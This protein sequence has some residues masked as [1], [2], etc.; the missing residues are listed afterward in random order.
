MRIGFLITYFYPKIGGAENNC[1]AL[2]REL[3][4]K[5]EVHVFCS[6]E[7][8]Q[9]EKIFGINVHRC[10]E[11][12]RI[13][14]YF[15]F[16]PSLIKKL[17][18][19]ELDILHVHGLGFP[20]HDNAIIKLKRLRPGLKLVC[21]PHGPFMAL[22]KYNLLGK[23]FKFFYTPIIARSMKKF[24]K[25]IQVNPNQWKW[26][27]SEYNIPK[28]K[29]VFLPNGIDKA[30]LKIPDHQKIMALKKKYG[31]EGKFV[32]S[33]LG[34]IQKYK[35][36]DQI[37]KILPEVSKTKNNMAFLIIGKDS[38]DKSRLI[39]LAKELKI[40]D[41][42]IFTGEVNEEDKRGLLY[43]SEIFLFP[44][45]WEAFGIVLLEAMAMKNAVISTKTEGGLYL[46]KKENGFL[47]EY[48]DLNSLKVAINKIAEDDITRVKMQKEN[49]NKAKK[50]LW[51]DIAI[52]LE[53][54]YENTRK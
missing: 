35:G 23:L 34:R 49:Y 11:I 38:G 51:E 7:Y 31:L 41:R 19:N 15:A 30:A 5:H 42:L 10:K 20:Q 53:K 4:K 45:E 3:A 40:L 36:V 8:D 43:L 9:E 33:Y 32:I 27:E 14:Y 21:T 1:L 52:N 28:K 13:K 17:I 54:I 24:D 2:A 18:S 46:V 25:I 48:Q 44:S 22:R 37:I 29:I 50:F 39:N 47:F 26:M 6:G 12:F 16:Y